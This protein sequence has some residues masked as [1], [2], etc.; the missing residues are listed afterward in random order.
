LLKLNAQGK[1]S[2]VMVRIMRQPIFFPWYIRSSHSFPIQV[3]APCSPP[4]KPQRLE[5]TVRISNLHLRKVGFQIVHKNIVLGL[6]QSTRAHH[7]TNS[8]ITKT[9]Q[10]RSISESNKLQF[11]HFTG[12]QLSHDLDAHLSLTN[13]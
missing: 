1:C 9:G 10:K 7:C 12:T 3:G 2:N 11:P 5:C 13:T 6:Q 4:P 8:P